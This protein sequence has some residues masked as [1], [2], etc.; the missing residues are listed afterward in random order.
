MPRRLASA[1]S[2]LALLCVCALSSADP[3]DLEPLR[4]AVRE[5]EARDLDHSDPVVRSNLPL[6]RLKLRK[7]ELLLTPGK[8][9]GPV[10]DAARWEVEQGF[11]ALARLGEGAVAYAGDYTGFAWPYDMSGGGSGAPAGYAPAYYEYALD[12]NTD[13]SPQPFL[14]EV[15]PGYDPAR[16]WPLLVYLH[17]YHGRVDMIRKW[18]TRAL[19][20]LAKGQGYLV[21]APQGRS[22]TDF[23]GV[24]EADAL[25]AVREVGRYYRIDPERVYLIGGSM[26]GHGALNLALHYPHMWAA[27]VANVASSD[28]MLF[29][30]L[31]RDEIPPFR[32]WHFL[33]STPL[34]LAG[35]APA[36]PIHCRHGGAD[37]WVP[38]VHTERFSERRLALGGLYEYQIVPGAGHA[39]CEQFAP[40]LEWL[41]GR[42]RDPRPKLVRHKTFSLRYDRSYWVRILDIAVWGEAAEIQAQVEGN[43]VTVSTTNVPAYELTLGDP[44]VDVAQPVR[45]VSNGEVVF[46]DEVDSRTPV[47]VG[48]PPVAG[49]RKTPTLCGAVDDI[50][51]H[52]FLV[53]RGTI[54]EDEARRTRVADDAAWFRSRWEAYTDGW[55]RMKDD[56]EVTEADI[57]RYGL[58]LL[59]RP[60]ENA[61][62]ARV[63]EGLP[64]GFVGDGFS[65]GGQRYEGGDLGLALVYPNPLNPQRYAGVLAGARY[66]LGLP[67]NHPFSQLPDVLIFRSSGVESPEEGAS[68]IFGRPNQHLFAAFFDSAWRLSEDSTWLGE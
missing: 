48:A 60:T 33:R 15:P 43:E 38:Q 25:Q 61:L 64:V 18:D 6:A 10:E 40:G 8:Y 22:E 17:G 31:P 16:A 27:V 56:V 2:A 29:G 58:L 23:L 11:A 24:G 45:V 46:E 1:A 35:N 54:A 39:V 42:V 49:L 37:T 65:V 36:L 19:A 34:D 14:V 28:M 66:G 5:Q 21:V 7:A 63:A 62:T 57:E 50:F 9:E 32:R 67:E 44:L 53:V 30:G 47:R 12:S 52:P 3:V 55:P 51:S 59:G 4:E 41:K 26:G 20:D 68:Q 13:G